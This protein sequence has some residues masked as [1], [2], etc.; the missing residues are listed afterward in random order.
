MSFTKVALVLTLLPLTTFAGNREGNGGDEIRAAYLRAGGAVIQFFTTVPEGMALMST[1]ELKVDDL[2]K[3]LTVDR[4]SVVEG[5]LLDSTGSVVDALT[6][7]GATKLSKASWQSHFDSEKDVYYLV[8]HE[9]LRAMGRGMDDENFAITKAL[10]PFPEILKVKTRLAPSYPLFPDE[11]LSNIFQ[12]DKLVFGGK[13][14]PSKQWGTY[15]DFDMERNVID[16]SLS[17]LIVWAGKLAYHGSQTRRECDLAIPMNVPAGKRLKVTQMDLS[18]VV[19]APDNSKVTISTEIFL[20]GK[21]G[22]RYSKEVEGKGYA[23]GGTLLREND[24]LTTECGGSYLLRV[25]TNARA[26][27]NTWIPSGAILRKQSLYLKLEN[28]GG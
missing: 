16:L 2:Q 14:C 24:V 6:E 19:S 11:L 26:E 13:G 8:A 25:R 22:K 9:M 20:A 27:G 21:S 15:V 18:A 3:T 5:I 17:R 10:R 23:G 4:I 7:N 12:V 1:H 28:C